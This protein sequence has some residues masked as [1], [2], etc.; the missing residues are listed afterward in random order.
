M[1]RFPHFH[2]AHLSVIA[3]LALAPAAY[4][5]SETAAAAKP[6]AAQI[7]EAK[8][9]ADDAAK[10]MKK[11]QYSEAL[12]K[13]TAAY[14]IDP[15]P[16]TLAQIGTCQRELSQYVEAYA[17]YERLLATEKLPAKDKAA[18]QKNLDELSKLTGLLRVT[19]S[20]A[21]AEL[22]LDGVALA[23]EAA[24]KPIRVLPGRHK[25]VAKKA[26]FEPFEGEV[27]VAAGAEAAIEG[28]L[29]AEMNTARVRIAEKSG[30]EVR[31]FIDGKDVGPAPWEGELDPGQHVVELK[32]A[33]FAS[34][35]QTI[36][37]AAKQRV[38]LQLE[39]SN[40]QGRVKLTATPADAIVLVDG[41]QLMLPFEGGLDV[42]THRVEVSAP[43]YDKVEREIVV[44]A[45]LP[46]EETFALTAMPAAEEASSERFVK[47]GIL[48]GLLSLPRP[49][50]AEVAVKLGDYFAIGGQYSMLPNMT[51]P[52]KD[53][54]AK[55]SAIQGTLR[56]F[57]F[58]GAFYLGVNG[59][60][61]TLTASMSEGDLAVESDMSSPIIAPQL[62][63]LWTWDSGFTL[64]LNFGVQIPLAKDPEVKVKYQGVDVSDAPNQIPDQDKRDKANSLKDSVQSVAKLVG[65][66]PLPQIDLLKIGFF[67]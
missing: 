18:A 39:A 65:K 47:P 50:E 19:V 55:F 56:T 34:K 62:G 46:L 53:A 63:W 59:G 1:P 20:E 29:A 2:A 21:G 3:C 7:K 6:T 30:N 28:K 51:F 5:Q 57:P 60:I 13:L 9:D 16:A 43:G 41:E 58:G 22:A 42:G 37:L 33:R 23:A 24:A 4:A 12:P 45:E 15:K 52:G 38:D 26:G 35:K 54:K 31:V 11:K 48:L 8:R 44:T 27:E 32:G 66:T 49:V 14:A 36:D 10:L 61:Q 67:F 64:G 17:T 25:L 40:Q